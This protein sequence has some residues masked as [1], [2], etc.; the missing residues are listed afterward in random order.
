MPIGDP[1]VYPNPSS[2]LNRRGPSQQRLSLLASLPAFMAASSP[3]VYLPNLYVEDLPIQRKDKT[4]SSNYKT[5][6]VKSYVII[7]GPG[8]LVVMKAGESREQQILKGET[9]P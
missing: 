2:G 9:I 5:D 6:N 1:G 4:L 3:E 7:M 8:L